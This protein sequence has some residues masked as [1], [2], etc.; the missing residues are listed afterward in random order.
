MGYIDKVKERE[1]TQ[2]YKISHE[3]EIRAYQR[4]YA[5]EYRLC[6]KEKIAQYYAENREARLIRQRERRKE[7]KCKYPWISSFY[8]AKE[9]CNNPNHDAYKY[10]GGR[11]IRFFLTKEELSFIWERDGAGTMKK[12][13]I[14]RMDSGG[15]YI[16]ANCRFI[17]LAENAGR[18]ETRGGVGA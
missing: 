11:G 4:K 13:S 8:K 10:Y 17:E 9:R 3:S 7:V 16:F 1:T 15:H 2:R 6:N 18:C 5:R 12:P 14:D